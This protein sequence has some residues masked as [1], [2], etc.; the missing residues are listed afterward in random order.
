MGKGIEVI[1]PVMV[2]PFND[3]ERM[4]TPGYDVVSITGNVR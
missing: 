4:D 3:R 2:T 1:I